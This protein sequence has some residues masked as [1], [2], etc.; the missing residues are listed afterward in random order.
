MR[1][2]AEPRV[3]MGIST[4]VAREEPT[5]ADDPEMP[6][7]APLKGS[8]V[9]I[10]F[11]DGSGL[12][13]DS[14]LPVADMIEDLDACLDEDSTARFL[15]LRDWDGTVHYMNIEQIADITVTEEVLVGDKVKAKKRKPASKASSAKSK[16][17]V[18]DKEE[19]GG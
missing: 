19:S 16:R 10:D 13:I 4:P 2:P 8:R 9:H 7:W 14:T 12:R 1:N 11:T 15:S 3:T 5:V 17:P 6:D 18:K